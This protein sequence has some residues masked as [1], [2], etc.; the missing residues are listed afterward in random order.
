VGQPLNEGLKLVGMNWSHASD[1]TSLDSTQRMTSPRTMSS[2][3]ERGHKFSKSGLWS[4]A[5]PSKRYSVTLLD[6][7]SIYSVVATRGTDTC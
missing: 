3:F 5:Q 1:L 2:A 7:T 6:Q 4:Y